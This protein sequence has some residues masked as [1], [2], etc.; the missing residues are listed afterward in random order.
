MNDVTIRP[1]LWVPSFDVYSTGQ[2]QLEA[3]WTDNEGD[4]SE[5]IIRLGIEGDKPSQALTD[6][7]ARVLTEA[8]EHETTPHPWRHGIVECGCAE[9][10]DD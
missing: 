10:G 8:I 6:H 4:R 3:V 2:W 1:W 5:K 9:C 7:L